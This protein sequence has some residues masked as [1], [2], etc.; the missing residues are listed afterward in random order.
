[1][2]V[3]PLNCWPGII[4][5]SSAYLC[6]VNIVYSNTT[7]YICGCNVPFNTSVISDNN[8]I[9]LD[10]KEQRRTPP[11]TTHV[12]NPSHSLCAHLFVVVSMEILCRH[13]VLRQAA[14]DLSSSPGVTGHAWLSHGRTAHKPAKFPWDAFPVR[15]I[16]TFIY[17]L[18][19]D[20]AY[21]LSLHGPN[22]PPSLSLPFFLSLSLPHTQNIN[23][24]MSIYSVPFLFFIMT[25]SLQR[26]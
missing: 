7:A 6:A 24:H 13:C 18:P 19:C 16:R 2:W 3:T 20:F 17:S 12:H 4:Q 11:P 14:L 9:K 21:S 8:T 23:I 26:L 15:W 22:T 5:H 25:T 1:M 10:L